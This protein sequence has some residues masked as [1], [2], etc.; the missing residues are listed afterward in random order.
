MLGFF[1]RMSKL[2]SK[3]VRIR[4]LLLELT[5]IVTTPPKG[6]TITSP[7]GPL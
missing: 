4:L 3:F 7:F 6:N 1:M 2:L 5:N